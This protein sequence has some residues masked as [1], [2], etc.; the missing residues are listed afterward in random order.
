ML[1]RVG[2]TQVD[3]RMGH[4]EDSDSGEDD[5]V[6]LIDLTSRGV[7][8]SSVKREIADVSIQNVFV[9]K[10]LVRPRFA[11]AA[12]FSRRQRSNCENNDIAI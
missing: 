3:A 11:C 2:L 9:C 4:L 5:V 6:T 10:T 8:S 1:E 7:R 12:D